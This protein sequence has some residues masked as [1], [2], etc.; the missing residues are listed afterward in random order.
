ML[1]GSDMYG[2][3]RSCL[4]CGFVSESLSLPAIDLPDESSGGVRRRRR[5]PSHGN[6]RI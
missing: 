1:A 6:L 4:A 2:S 5:E 3:Y